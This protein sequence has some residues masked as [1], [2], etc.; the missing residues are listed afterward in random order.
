MQHEVNVK[1]LGEAIQ[2]H[3]DAKKLTVR[4][5]AEQMENVSAST[6]SRIER[7][8]VPDL[9]T[10]MRLCRWLEVDP[11]FFAVDV[12]DKPQTVKESALK[13]DDIIVHLRADKLL[14][15]STREALITMI[16]VAYAAARRNV[17]PN[18][19]QL[20]EEGI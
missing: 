8:N 9:D 11:S 18:E 3:R 20:T 1:A 12:T 17:L 13:T 2:R 4:A 19:T 5:A 6:L 15:H 16:E 7:G 10:Y 14:N